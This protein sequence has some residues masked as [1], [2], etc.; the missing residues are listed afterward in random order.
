MLST[1][2]RTVLMGFLLDELNIQ[3]HDKEGHDK[4]E[5]TQTFHVAM[6][7]GE[8]EPGVCCSPLPPLP[9]TCLLIYFKHTPT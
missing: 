8:L 7:T 4:D 9:L 2:C 1:M 6:E 3:S 5:P